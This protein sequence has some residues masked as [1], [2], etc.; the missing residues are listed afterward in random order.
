MKIS[1]SKEIEELK[2]RI[3]ELEKAKINLKKR[4]EALAESE[5]KYR[6]IFENTGTA[7]IIV[8]EDMTVSLVNSEFEKLCGFYKKDIENIKKWTEF[9]LKKDLQ[10]MKEYHIKRRFE[11]GSAPRNYEC[12]FKDRE[13]NVKFI[14]MTVDIIPGTKKSVLS[15]LDITDRKRAEENYKRLYEEYNILLEAIPDMILLISSEL[16]ILWANNVAKNNFNKENLPGKKCF[17]LFCNSL[18][19]CENCPVVKSFSSGKEEFARITTKE[20]KTFEIKI[21]PIKDENGIIN[22]A[23]VIAND[24]TE[25][26]FIEKEA[27]RTSQLASI[28]ELAAGVAHEINNPITGIISFAELL[29]DKAKEDGREAYIYKQI[30]KEGDRIA[31]ITKSLLSFARRQKQEKIPVKIKKIISSSLALIRTRLAKDDIKINTSIPEELPDIVAD[32]YELQQVFMN[33]LSNCH[34]GLNKKFPSVNDGKIIEISAEEVIKEK[35]GFIRIKFYDYGCGIEN[36]LIRRVFNPFF[37]T[38][39]SGE[40]T[41]LGLSISYGIISDHGGNILID[42]QEGKFTEVTLELPVWRE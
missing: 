7:T 38:K 22:R 8:E 21:N 35:D 27:I 18:V 9:F 14:F 5:K 34:Y 15:L 33:I 24:I 28:G 29:L 40:G 2:K 16:E 39:P 32:P 19:P 23:I 4:D 3:K 11:Q 13:G 36:E 6:A 10:R 37:T 42:S 1:E 25:K 20:N 41:G 17:D 26:L 12:R 31:N 30:I